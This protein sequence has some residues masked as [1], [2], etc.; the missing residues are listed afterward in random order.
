[1]PE[2][3]LV[4]AICLYPINPSLLLLVR[5]T[6]QRRYWVHPM[7]MIREET[8]MRNRIEIMRESYP[9]RFFSYFRVKPETFNFI[10]SSIRATIQ[11]ANTRMRRCIDPETRLYVTLHFLASGSSYQNIAVHYALGRSTI[12]GIVVDTCKAIVDVLGPLYLKVPS[13]HAE[14]NSIAER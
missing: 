12:S 14:W 6:D 1:M 8:S 2:R 5:Q 10:L 7:N 4:W 11:R 9:D 13:T 3:S